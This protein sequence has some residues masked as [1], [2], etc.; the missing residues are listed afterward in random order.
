MK[1]LEGKTAFVTGAAQGNGFGISK[2][3]MEKGA[4]VIMTDKSGIVKE[5]EKKLE[6]MTG[7]QGEHILYNGRDS[8]G[9]RGRSRKR[10]GIPSGI[11]R[12]FSQ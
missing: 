2:V 7:Q 10:R 5:S 9:Q 12:Y 11:H 4:C 1:P 8:G 3:L 6:E